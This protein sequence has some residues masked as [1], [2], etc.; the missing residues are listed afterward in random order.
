MRCR[1]QQNQN[2]KPKRNHHS[3]Y[4]PQIAPRQAAKPGVKPCGSQTKK[5]L[6]RGGH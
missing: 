5:Q 3:Q 2:S 6:E 4:Y 1:D